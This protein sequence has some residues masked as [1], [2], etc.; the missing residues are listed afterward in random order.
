MEKYICYGICKYSFGAV[1]VVIA[2]G[3]MFLGNGVV[4]VME[5]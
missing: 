4:L 1:L 2:V 5:V 3:L